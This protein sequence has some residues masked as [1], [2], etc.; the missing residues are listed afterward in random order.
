MNIIKPPNH[1]K[2]L[3]RLIVS[4][5]HFFIQLKGFFYRKSNI[6]DLYLGISRQGHKRNICKLIWILRNNFASGN[7]LL[8]ITKQQFLD[9]DAVRPKNYVRNSCFV[10]FSS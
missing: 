10:V 5:F 4:M 7:K 1:D 9:V 8:H 3:E 6:N 2:E